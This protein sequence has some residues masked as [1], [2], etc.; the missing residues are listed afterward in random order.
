LY[1]DIE[2]SS[3]TVV[4][5][6]V[7]TNLSTVLYET[8]VCMKLLR[9]LLPSSVSKVGL[10]GRNVLS[11]L[12]IIKGIKMED[13]SHGNIRSHFVISVGFTS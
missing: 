8:N 7:Q 5:W 3:N 9:W 13:K 4:P 10:I 1:C 2:A 6:L 12:Y 11:A